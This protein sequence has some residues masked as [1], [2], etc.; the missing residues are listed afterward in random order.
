MGT[1]KK[2]S[3]YAVKKGRNPGLY[4]SWDECRKQVMGFAGALYKGFYTKEEAEAYLEGKEAAA[5]VKS[6]G[7]ENSMPGL[8]VYVD[9]SYM[10]FWPDR[11]SYG[12]V[13]LE[14][15]RVY[16]ESKAFIDPENAQMRNVAGEVA[17]ARRA[18]EYCMERGISEV[19]LFYDYKGIECWCV[20]EWK[21]NK[22]GTKALKAYYDEVKGR[23]H[24]AF[25]KVKSHSGVKYNE[26]ADRL[27]KKALEDSQ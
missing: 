18:M 16:T 8:S 7:E 14:S 10:P 26:M 9:G 4:T 22:E 27:A 1:S 3:W 20:G 23:L 12:I 17:G 25:H 21:A 2:K 6:K 13:Y 11:Y 19:H 5:F 24:V 15:G